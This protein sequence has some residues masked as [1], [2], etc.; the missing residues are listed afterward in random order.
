MRIAQI[1]TASAWTKYN[2]QSASNDHII[3][4]VTGVDPTIDFYFDNSANA[5]VARFDED[6]TGT[7]KFTSI[8]Y[9]ALPS[10]PTTSGLFHHYLMT[11][12]G[13]YVKLYFDGLLVATSADLAG[14]IP[15]QNPFALLGN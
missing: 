11:Y 14:A 2:G 3:Y 8:L 13:Q 12:D 15:E 7:P 10:N 5:V 6:G 4:L 1:F 9:T